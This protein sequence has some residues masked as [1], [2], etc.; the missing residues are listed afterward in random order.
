MA[1]FLI[2]ASITFKT[3]SPS[4]LTCFKANVF[5]CCLTIA[6]IIAKVAGRVIAIIPITTIIST[7]VKPRDFFILFK[8]SKNSFNR[9]II[10]VSSQTPANINKC[11]DSL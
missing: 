7:K 8:F 6:K 5:A 1:L 3:K 4:L 11:A 10:S 9:N 2:A